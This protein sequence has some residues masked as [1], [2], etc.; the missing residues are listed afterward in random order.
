LFSSTQGRWII[1]GAQLKFDEFWRTNG[2]ISQCMLHGGRLPHIQ[3]VPWQRW[4]GARLT[5]DHAINVSVHKVAVLPTEVSLTAAAGCDYAEE[6]NS[7]TVEHAADRWVPKDLDDQP[8]DE[9]PAFTVEPLRKTVE[10]LRLVS[11]DKH[12]A[13]QGE[14]RLVTDTVV[15]GHPLYELKD[16]GRWLYTGLDGRWYVG[17]H[18]SKSKDFSCSSGYIFHYVPHDGKLPHELEGHWSWGDSCSWHEDPA[19]TVVDTACLA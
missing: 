10:M 13:C 1:G 7:H 14:Y 18:I 12:E 19:I 9:H 8:T 17:G 11:S 16:R 2:L 4:T 5:E 3:G 6:D 15:N